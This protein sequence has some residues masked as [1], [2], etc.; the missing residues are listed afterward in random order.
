MPKLKISDKSIHDCMWAQ[1]LCPHFSAVQITDTLYMCNHCNDDLSNAREAV[2][3]LEAD[4]QIKQCSLP[5][6]T[7]SLACKLPATEKER[8]SAKSRSS[9]D[10]TWRRV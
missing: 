5:L 8:P 3:S 2:T 10:T 1:T 9:P 6:P 4:Y 7:A